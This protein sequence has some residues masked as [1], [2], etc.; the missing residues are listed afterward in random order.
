MEHMGKKTTAY[1]V[2]MEKLEETTHSEDVSVDRRTPLNV[3]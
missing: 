1:C 2:L 3:Y